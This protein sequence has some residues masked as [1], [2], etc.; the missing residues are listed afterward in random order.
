MPDVHYDQGKGIIRRDSKV[1]GEVDCRGNT[2]NK[3]TQNKHRDADIKRVG[4]EKSV[5][6]KQR[7]VDHIALKKKRD[8]G[9][10][11]DHP[12]ILCQREEGEHSAY[13]CKEQAERT[14][15]HSVQ[16]GHQHLER[17]DA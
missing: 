8:H 4:R 15:E 17:V 7:R 12:V 2:E 16:P 10:D 13:G 6:K 5:Q 11:S 1:G 3:E 9:C 14:G